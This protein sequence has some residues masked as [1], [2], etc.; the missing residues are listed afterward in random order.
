M[1]WI[2]NLLSWRHWG[3]IR[4]NSLWQNA[5]A[6]FYLALTHHLYSWSFPT[7]VALFILFSMLS[8]SYG[9]LVND[10][11]DRELDQ[12]HGKPNVFSG[13][14]RVR[15]LAAVG[16][17]AVGATLA[18]LPFLH[19]PWFA[20]LWGAWFCTATFYSLPP[21]R[22]KERGLSGLVAAI[23]AQQTLPTLLIFAAFGHLAS[24]G[25]LVFVIYATA[26]GVSSDVGHQMRDW[27]QDAETET[28]TF[29][30]RQGYRSICRLYA[31]CQELDKL[32]LGL[33]MVVLMVDLPSVS[34]PGLSLQVGLAWPLVASYLVLYALTAGQG[35]KGLQQGTLPDPY[36][37]IPQGP[38]RNAIHFI[39][40]AFPSVVIPFYLAIWMTLFYRPNGVF[41]LAL[42][43]L[44]RLYSPRRWAA[45]WPLRAF[46]AQVRQFADEP[47]RFP[48][49]ELAE[50]E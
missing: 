2:I 8:T 38:E 39:H 30:V 20:L 31:T 14:G 21:L 45:A 4:Y 44:Y 27:A 6:V 34:L 29:A 19:R 43:L 36:D 49:D 26:R 24:W 22:F 3:I 7:Q 48:I 32:L 28:P 9:Y 16:T 41:V 37:D 12:R 15:P 10:L 25:A 42:I 46:G 35:W 13:M 40:H 18:S 11:A 17:M 50:V 23:F 33:V 5:A 47:E 1:I